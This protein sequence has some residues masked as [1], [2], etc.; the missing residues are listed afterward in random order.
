MKI[1]DIEK[2][3]NEQLIEIIKKYKICPLKPMSRN[4]AMEHVKKFLQSKVKVDDSKTVSIQNQ[5]NRQ[6]RM[7]SAN[8]TQTKRENIPQND[9]KHER[10]RRMSQPTTSTE[11]T[12]AQRDHELKQV[13]NIQNQRVIDE[14]NKKMPQYDNI[15]LYPSTKRLVA[16]GDVHGDLKVTIVKK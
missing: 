15:G 1:S 12:T 2:L 14:L 7:S 3:R 9:V 4:I 10:D 16:I 13:Q 5:Q 11:K 6:R 8:S